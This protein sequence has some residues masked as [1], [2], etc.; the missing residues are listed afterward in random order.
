MGQSLWHK[1]DSSAWKIPLLSSKTLIDSIYCR[2]RMIMQ[3]DR[4]LI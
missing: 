3:R 1:A 2:A 4:K